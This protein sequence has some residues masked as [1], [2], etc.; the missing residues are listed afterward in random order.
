M[1]LENTGEEEQTLNPEWEIRTVKVVDEELDYPWVEEE[2]AGL[3]PVP[4][5]L[6][7][8]QKKKK[9]KKRTKGA[10]RGI[11]GCLCR[12]DFKLGNTD[13]IE[14]DIHTKG[15]PIW[16]PHQ[17]QNPEVQ[18]HEQDQLKEMLEQEII[19]LSCSPWASPVVIVEKKDA[20]PL[21]RIHG[22][23]EALKGVKLFSTLDFKSGYWQVPIKEEH[24]GKTAFQ[25]TLGQLYEFNRCPFGPCTSPA[26]FSRLIG[27]VL[28]GLS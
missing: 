24:K 23:L 13:L 6:T 27:Y 3:P 7:T 25:T 4:E 16:Q 9:K 15:P 5:E 20:H 2:E 8:M 12:K 17:R 10:V 18:R 21:P 28:S 19:R 14:H 11:S 26:T 22:T 1:R